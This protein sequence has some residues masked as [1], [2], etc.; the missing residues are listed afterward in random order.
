MEQTVTRIPTPSI[1]LDHLASLA[2][3]Q[4]YHTLCLRLDVAAFQEPG[5]S[6]LKPG[7]GT[8]PCSKKHLKPVGYVIGHCSQS[9]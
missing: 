9:Q 5:F 4:L 2:V 7:L 3:S 6:Y 8:H 1:V